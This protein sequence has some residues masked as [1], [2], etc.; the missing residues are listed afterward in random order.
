MIPP[1]QVAS[2]L[3]SLPIKSEADIPIPA[4]VVYLSMALLASNGLFEEGLFRK[5]IVPQSQ[6]HFSKALD[7]GFY[8]LPSDSPHTYA[9]LL[10]VFLK[11]LT[12]PPVP[13]T[14]YNGAI[15]AA[16]SPTAALNFAST[17][18]PA[19][20]LLLLKYLFRLL[21]VLS[22]RTVAARNKS[23]ASNMALYFTPLVLRMLTENPAEA[24]KNL[25]KEIQFVY[26]LLVSLVP[27]DEE[28]AMFAACDAF[29]A[30]KCSMQIP[31]AVSNLFALDTAVA[32]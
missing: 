6:E 25:R 24:V 12:D 5:A 29:I 2:L 14:L 16:D 27:T 22:S 21:R 31:L 15:A 1:S 23:T 3:T 17:S 4:V 18:L 9:V 32:P 20:N 7:D 8:N 13:F 11:R 19:P 28:R 10:K 30:A 26:A